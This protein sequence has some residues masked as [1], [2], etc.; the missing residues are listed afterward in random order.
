MRFACLCT[1]TLSLTLASL[2]FGTAFAQNGSDNQR[3]GPFVKTDEMLG[4]L[5][6]QGY[7]IKGILGGAL[8]LVQDA[9]MYSCA[10]VPDH[11]ALS[12]KTQ[13]ECSVLDEIRSSNSAKSSEN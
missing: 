7:E 10:L 3:H 4:S 1:A 13:F 11:E 12:Y 5:L 9:K 6:E 8:I 2:G